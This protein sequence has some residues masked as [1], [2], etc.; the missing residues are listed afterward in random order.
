MV[1]RTGFERHSAI[2]LKAKQKQKKK[3]LSYI[4]RPQLN[5]DLFLRIGVKKD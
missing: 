4:D 2:D 5:S 1:S 3:R